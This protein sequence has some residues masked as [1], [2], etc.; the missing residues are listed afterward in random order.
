MPPCQDP[1]CTTTLDRARNFYLHKTVYPSLMNTVVFYHG[2][3]TLQGRSDKSPPSYRIILRKLLNI[4]RITRGRRTSPESSNTSF[5]WEVSL[6]LSYR[7]PDSSSIEGQT[8]FL[9]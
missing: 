8:P 3:F 6:T 7:I 2:H 1:Q 9:F 5:L 4:R